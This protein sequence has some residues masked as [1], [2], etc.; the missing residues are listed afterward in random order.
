MPGSAADA[1][2]VVQDTFMRA[3][4]RPPGAHDEP[5]RPWLVK[6]ALNLAAR[7]AAAAGGAATTS[8]RG[9]RRRSR[10]TCPA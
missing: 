5:L 7:S 10:P 6:V 4:E 3:L 8:A 9:C 2:D 1:D